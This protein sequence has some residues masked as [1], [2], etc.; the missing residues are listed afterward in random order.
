MILAGASGWLDGE[1]VDPSRGFGEEK[2]RLEH[3]TFARF[4][5]SLHTSFSFFFSFFFFL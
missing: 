2:N 5:L 1:G 3:I 4:A